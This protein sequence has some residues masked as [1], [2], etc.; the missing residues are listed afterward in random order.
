MRKTSSYRTQVIDGTTKRIG[1]VVLL[2]T[3]L[4]QAEICMGKINR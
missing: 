2:Q 1:S 4:A 3:V